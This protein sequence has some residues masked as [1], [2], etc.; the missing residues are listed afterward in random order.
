[1]PIF[2]P[3]L[4]P[5]DFAHK[6]VGLRL[7]A[8]AEQGDV[9]VCVPAS[10][11][12]SARSA[13]AD[14]T[15]GPLI[16]ACPSPLREDDALA[17]LLLH[18]RSRGDASSRRLHLASLP[19]SYEGVL[20]WSQAELE[21][22]QASPL[23]ALAARLQ[24]QAADDFAELASLGLLP[25]DASLPDYCWALATVHSRGMDLP[26]AGDEGLERLVVPF[27]DLANDERGL[28]TCHA[29]ERSS[30]AVVLLA[31]RD[32]VAGDE[33]CISYGG[34]DAAT[35]LRLHG[36][37]PPDADGSATVPVLAELPGGAEAY[38]RKRLLLD[39]AGV[40]EGMQH[41]LRAAC[42]LP[43]SLLAALRA[44]HLG[45]EEAGGEPSLLQRVSD[46]NETAALRTL[47]AALE[48]MAGAYG[49]GALEDELLL[50]GGGL[51]PRRQA[52]LALR[53]AEK[54]VLAAA[55]RATEARMEEEEARRADRA[56]AVAGA[57]PLTAYFQALLREEG[58][59][60]VSRL[61]G[62]LD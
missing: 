30:G 42:P 52:A 11:A 56:A 9:L 37:L 38:A 48:D 49:T 35:C 13:L 21:E 54:R 50:R 62:E 34:L 22:L 23:R 55:L 31:G 12:F 60:G 25:A 46:E 18:E 20:F 59:G 16:R 27:L 29:Y 28:D 10:L 43:D 40:R 51:A 4:E 53:L 3:L 26:V 1:V 47:H 44:L 14:E 58:E 15:L 33:V 32:G 36:F 2:R 19:S 17:L 6:G 41:L 61:D 45:A 39:E 57:A 24:A 8:P 5:A 7:L